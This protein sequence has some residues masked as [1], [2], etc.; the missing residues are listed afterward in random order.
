MA[1]F[2]VVSL[3]MATNAAVNNSQMTRL[4]ELVTPEV[5]G[6]EATGVP[7]A[8][9]T[10]SYSCGG[11]RGAR[12][13]TSSATTGRAAEIFRHREI[14]GTRMTGVA[15]ILAVADDAPQG[16]AGVGTRT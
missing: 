11:L 7:V 15:S 3:R 9:M 1:T 10:R 5:V 14:L 8:A 16:G 2:I 13:A 12:A 6:G 4:W